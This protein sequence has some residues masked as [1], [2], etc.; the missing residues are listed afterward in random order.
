MPL[1]V[2]ERENAIFLQCGDIKWMD[3]RKES[4]ADYEVKSSGNK[5]YV[6]EHS[7]LH[8]E[9]WTNEVN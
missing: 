4:F 7:L 2:Y 8:F 1:T 3:Y 5:R 6:S 9:Y